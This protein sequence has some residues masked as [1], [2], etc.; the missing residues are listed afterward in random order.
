MS[1]IDKQF[2]VNNKTNKNYKKDQVSNKIDI[3]NLIFSIICISSKLFN[4]IEKN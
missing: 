1:Q 4:L 3:K 2:D